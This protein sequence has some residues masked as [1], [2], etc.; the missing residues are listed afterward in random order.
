MESRSITLF[1]CLMAAVMISAS[2]AASTTPPTEGGI[3]PDIIL[4]SPQDAAHRSY[5][6]LEGKES[7]KIPEIRASVVI[8]EIFQYV[9]SALPERGAHD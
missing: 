8:I 3:L 5:L 2:V 4:E 6:G 1:G 9:L 7:F